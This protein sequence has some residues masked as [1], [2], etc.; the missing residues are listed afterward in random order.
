MESVKKLIEQHIARFP[1]F[2]YY[3]PII[4]KAQLNLESHPDI[5]IE[6]CKSLIEGLSK[7]IL[8]R[9]DQSLTRQQVDGW[10]VERLI[11]AVARKVSDYD[12][13]TEDIFVLKCY[14]LAKAMSYVRHERGDISH[15]RAA[16]KELQSN[17]KLGRLAL[18]MTECVACYLLDAFLAI[19][20]PEPSGEV[21]T[22]FTDNPDFNQYLDEEN[23][24]AGRV[25][26]SRALYDQYYE[27]YLIQLSDYQYEQELE[28][29]LE[30]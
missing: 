11:K 4:D 8:I 28:G 12:N 6:I 1:E 15:G 29:E 21:R 19:P 27:D 5:C 18:A 24:V 26:Y 14:E 23:P 25:L 16:P 2:S 10:S 17:A 7:S 9:V 20:D 3:L 13:M 22:E 30:E